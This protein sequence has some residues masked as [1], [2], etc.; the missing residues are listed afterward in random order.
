MSS[1][2]FKAMFA[3]AKLFDKADEDHSFSIEYEEFK[4][5]MGQLGIER[6]EEEIKEAFTVAD[7]DGSGSID[8][9]EFVNFIKSEDISENL[10]KLIG[11]ID[12]AEIEVTDETPEVDFFMRLMFFIADYEHK[13]S[14]SFEQFKTCMKNILGLFGINEEWPKVILRKLLTLPT[15]TRV[16]HLN[17]MIL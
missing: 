7:C 8:F 2:I 15:L 4:N 9:F 10:S 13:K 3:I 6:S 11:D 17:S 16:E 5:I 1:E 12:L 14:I